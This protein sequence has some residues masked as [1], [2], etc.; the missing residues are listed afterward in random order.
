LQIRGIPRSRS[1]AYAASAARNIRPAALFH[2][3]EDRPMKFSGVL[4]AVVLT[5]A[6]A[7]SAA[8]AQAGTTVKVV[9]ADVVAAATD[10]T[11]S[12]Y[13][14]LTD[15][16]HN[17]ATFQSALVYVKGLDAG[18]AASPVFEVILDNGTSQAD[19]GAL[20][21]FGHSQ[22]RG[23][24]RFDTRKST[25]VTDLTP[26]SGGTLHVQLAGVDVATA[27]IPAFVSPEAAGGGSG[28]PTNSIAFGF[29]SVILGDTSAMGTG[30]VAKVSAFAGN[31][32]FGTEQDIGVV[33]YGFTSGATYTVVLTGT[34]EDTLG[35]FTVSG[36]WGWGGLVVSTRHG[37]VIPGG[38]VSALAGRGIEIRDST[39]AAVLTGTFPSLN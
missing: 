34:T 26:F 17:G 6:V 32:W 22:T 36:F 11:E 28:G 2:F 14:R 4:S 15:V 3:E 27:T 31:S 18:G 13:L 24:L 8:V 5:A 33:G 25:T 39:G 21:I 35:T 30:P 7:G 23:W 37:G 20:T 1:E 19:L 16:E 38:S 10:G 9:R 29:G 12:G